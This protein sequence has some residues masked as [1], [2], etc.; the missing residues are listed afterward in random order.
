MFVMSYRDDSIRQEN[1]SLIGKKKIK[2]NDILIA[3]G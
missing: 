3:L 1:L 2:I